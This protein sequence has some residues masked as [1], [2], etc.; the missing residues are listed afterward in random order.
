MNFFRI[1]GCG[2]P[3]VRVFATACLLGLG[4]GLTAP[5][6]AFECD[7][8]DNPLDTAVCAQP[9]L[10]EKA[11]KIDEAVAHISHRSAHPEHIKENQKNWL[12]LA[13]QCA[14]NIRCLNEMLERRLERLEK[15]EAVQ[16][17]A[18]PKHEVHAPAKAGEHGEAHSDPHSAPH[19]E[20]PAAANSHANENANEHPSAKEGEQVK[21]D[22]G[23][24][25]GDATGS[26]EKSAEKS[27]EKSGE[28]HAEKMSEKDDDEE[29][30]PPHASGLSALGAAVADWV[31]AHPFLIVAL[32]V[33]SWLIVG[34]LFV[35]QKMGWLARFGVSLGKNNASAKAPSASSIAATTPG[36]PARVSGKVSKTTPAEKGNPPTKSG[37]LPPAAAAKPADQGSVLSKWWDRLGEKFSWWRFFIKHQFR[38][39]PKRAYGI[40]LLLVLTLSAVGFGVTQW[41]APLAS[42]APNATLKPAPAPEETTT[43]DKAEAPVGEPEVAKEAKEAKDVDEDAEKSHEA[44]GKEPVVKSVHTEPAEHSKH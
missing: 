28:K 29:A 32:L 19:A 1:T 44:Q 8:P 34:A 4:S 24:D 26:D 6:F 16:A 20:E 39:H 21:A 36:K 43:H 15:I 11:E 25:H 37:K 9:K 3:G 13:N 10:R 2:W 7:K 27:V 12:G 17:A 14:Q 38:N 33:A 5:A 35:V 41:T 23:H 22:G 42:S 18:P 40:S 31:K 30:Q